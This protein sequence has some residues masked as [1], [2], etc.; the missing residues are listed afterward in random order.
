MTRPDDDGTSALAPGYYNKD[1]N[2][3]YHRTVS[4]QDQEHNHTAEH[5][6]QKQRNHG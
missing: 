6:R 3:S 5:V 2:N 1:N 4:Y